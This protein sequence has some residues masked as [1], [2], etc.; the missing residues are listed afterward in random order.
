V[1]FIS[2]RGDAAEQARLK[3]LFTLERP[4]PET[5]NALLAGQRDDGGW[6]PF[7][8][9]NYSSLDA[10]C[11]RLAQAEQMG[12]TPSEPAIAH[13]VQFLA[14]RQHADG[15]WEEDASVA[16][17][18][19]PWARPGE[20]S[21]RLYLTANCG[22]WMAMLDGPGDGAL[23]AADCLHAHLGEDG[24]MPTFL[25]AHWLAGGLWHRMNRRESAERVFGH[26]ESKL[27]E[28]AVSNLAWLITALCAAG[29]PAS[30][31]LISTAAG[32]LTQHQSPDGRWPSEDGS[33]RDVHSTLESMRALR[34]C[35][36]F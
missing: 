16:S 33:D 8:A 5:I 30:H 29:V 36:R 19:P 14:Q 34:L 32:L 6:P 2:S 12:I 3:Y 4:S 1:T 21:T 25:H 10:T 31:R 13:A 35:G 18:A 7:W 20:V 15:S 23:R 28:L 24:N 17:A 11:F 26:L 22:F 9:S 27:S